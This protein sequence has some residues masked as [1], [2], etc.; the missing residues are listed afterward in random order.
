M[1]S[2]DLRGKENLLTA[3]KEVAAQRELATIERLEKDIA[4]EQ[5]KADS[6]QFPDSSLL[7]QNVG[8]EIKGKKI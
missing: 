1:E 2:G 3:V 4:A 8:K 5:I 7:Q 6:S